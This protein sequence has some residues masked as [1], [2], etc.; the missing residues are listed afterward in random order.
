[1]SPFK[2][3][4]CK[5]LPA[6][7]LFNDQELTSVYSDRKSLW[8]NPNDVPLIYKEMMIKSCKIR[9]Y[10]LRVIFQIWEIRD[11]QPQNPS[12]LHGT[13]SWSMEKL[14]KSVAGFVS[15]LPKTPQILQSSSA[16][17]WLTDKSHEPNVMHF[18]LRYI[19]LK[20]GPYLKE[21]YLWTEGMFGRSTIS[22]S[23]SLWQHQIV[24]IPTH[25][26]G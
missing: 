14:M 15:S 17:N 23:S 4:L 20:S 16:A 19:Y 1:M 12:L 3:K 11:L 6:R 24:R 22:L 25:L 5:D 9:L 21:T 13:K 7:T 26:E 18:K 2:L 10:Q 8:E